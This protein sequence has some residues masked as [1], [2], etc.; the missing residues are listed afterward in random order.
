M[1]TKYF[2]YDNTV[3]GISEHQYYKMQ[4]SSKKSQFISYTHGIKDKINA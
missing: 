4:Q 3:V 1:K 2:Q